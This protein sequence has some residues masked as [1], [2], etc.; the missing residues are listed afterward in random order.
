MGG[1]PLRRAK[2]KVIIKK[3]EKEYKNKVV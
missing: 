2:I 1:A 3:K